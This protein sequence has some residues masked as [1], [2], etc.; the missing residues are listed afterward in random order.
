MQIRREAYLFFG[1]VG[2]PAE[3]WFFPLAVWGVVA[4]SFGLEGAASLIF[5]LLPV[6][7]ARMSIG[8]TDTNK[9]TLGFVIQIHSCDVRYEHR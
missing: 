7:K 6:K 4:T 8:N 3:N 1:L 9:H 5:W 2:L